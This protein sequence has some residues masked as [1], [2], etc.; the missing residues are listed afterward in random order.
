VQTIGPECSASWC[1]VEI[2]AC[3]LVS[4]VLCP[5]LRGNLPAPNLQESK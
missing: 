2:R 4:E 3:G 1:T 5:D